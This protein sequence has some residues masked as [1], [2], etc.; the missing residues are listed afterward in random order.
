A[1]RAAVWNDP[2]FV[3]SDSGTSSEQVNMRASLESRGHDAKPFQGT[4]PAQWSNALAGADVL[5]IPDLETADP[6]PALGA[7]VQTRIAGFVKR[8]GLLVISTN[9]SGRAVTLLNSVF[10]FALV[11]TNNAGPYN[12]TA[13]QIGTPFALG[14]ASLPIL[15]A[16]RSVTNVP[17]G[18]RSIYANG[19][20]AAVLCTQ[21]GPG[22]P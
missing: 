9:A 5:V 6:T 16:T 13:D 19:A 4:T 15:N 17:P 3:N 1:R 20:D 2:A 18:S 10:G 22:H 11:Q 12:A 7:L 21:V 14:P 8:G